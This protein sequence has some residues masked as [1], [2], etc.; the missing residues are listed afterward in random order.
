LHPFPRT[1]PTDHPCQV[2]AHQD[3]IGGHFNNSKFLTGDGGFLQALVH[4]YGGIRIVDSG[5]KVCV[6][7]RWCQRAVTT[8]VFHP[9]SDQPFSEDRVYRRGEGVNCF[10]CY[11]LVHL[12]DSWLC[13][14][15]LIQVVCLCVRPFR[16]PFAPMS[17]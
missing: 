7:V 14:R 12:L 2:D 15:S 9:V 11:G 3:V 5:L 6:T 17:P 16:L 13:L 1:I 10:C 4:G 8:I